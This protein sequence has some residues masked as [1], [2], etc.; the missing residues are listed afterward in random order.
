[1]DDAHHGIYFEFDISWLVIDELN[2]EEDNV[3]VA[4]LGEDTGIKEFAEL[5]GG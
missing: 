4:L 3:G 2:L 5:S 1:M